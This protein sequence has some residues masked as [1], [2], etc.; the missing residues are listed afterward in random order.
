M[1]WST[2]PRRSATRFWTAL[3]DIQELLR[4]VHERVR[5]AEDVDRVDVPPGDG[6]G[7]DT[8]RLARADVERRVAH[9]GRLRRLGLEQLERRE[10][11][12]RVGLVPLGHVR[13]DDGVEVTLQR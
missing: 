1:W 5:L 2:S 4:A 3:E 12:R 9:E 11:G 7:E 13:R 10:H 6:H 8:G